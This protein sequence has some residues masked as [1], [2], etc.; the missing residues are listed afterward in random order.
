[1]IGTDLPMAQ[2]EPEVQKM[3]E[4][5]AKRASQEITSGMY[6]NLGVGFSFEN[7]QFLKH[8]LGIPTIV[9]NFLPNDVKIFL[10]GENGVLGIGH[11]PRVNE[12]DPDMI[13]AGG[14]AV[15]VNPGASY[16][17]SSMS[18]GMYRGRHMNATIIGGMQVSSKGDI[19][20]WVVP[21]KLL[22]VNI[23]FHEK[24]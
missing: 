4:K 8:F 7:V 9:M 24:N 18:F 16:F 2:K 23:N 6:V 3:R 12:E 1:M 20:N 5:I 14:E 15:S 13:N 17:S 11:Y 21:N 22:K 19:A 10:Q